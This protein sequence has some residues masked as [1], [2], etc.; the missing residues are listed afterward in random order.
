[1]NDHFGESGKPDEL[2]KHFGLD[3][4]HIA[5]AAH[6]LLMDHSNHKH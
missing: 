4:A 6:R 3:E 1:M 2:L 5:M